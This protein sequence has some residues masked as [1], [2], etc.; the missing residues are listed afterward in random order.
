MEKITEHLRTKP[1]ISEILVWDNRTCRGGKVPQMPLTRV[2]NTDGN[3]V[4]YGRFLAAEQAANDAIFFQDD[5]LICTD[6]DKIYE[7]WQED[8]SKI[9]AGL[10]SDESS[11]HFDVWE[12]SR[13]A[14]KQKPYLDMGF[15]AFF[16]ADK[17]PTLHIWIARYGVT[18][19]LYR[20]ADKI[21]TVLNRRC[22]EAIPIQ[23]ERLK[24]PDGTEC[25]RD[26]HALS[27]QPDHE[28]LTN[29]AVTKA[30]EL[31]P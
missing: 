25:G 27:L 13:I 26:K 24:H 17:L 9:V 23:I 6:I 28:E 10:P 2:L 7:K 19:L 5:D 22:C 1:Y 29:E 18:Y 30:L 3:Q 21:F 12:R 11:R 14:G 8:P 15:G 4:T 16:H 20:K 31:M